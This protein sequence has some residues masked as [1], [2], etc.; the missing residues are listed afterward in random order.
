LAAVTCFST[1]SVSGD[2]LHSST[3]AAELKLLYAEMRGVFVDHI[4]AG[5]RVYG[6][7]GYACQQG[8]GWFNCGNN[9]R[10]CIRPFGIALFMQR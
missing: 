3:K 7:D 2:E 6:L 9:G 8:V 4:L 5:N 1:F 10:F